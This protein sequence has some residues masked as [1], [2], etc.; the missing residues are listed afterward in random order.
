MS[1]QLSKKICLFTLAIGTVSNLFAAGL[2]GDF[3]MSDRWRR[4][5]SQYSNITNPA[6]INENGRMTGRALFTGVHEISYM[7]EMGFTMPLGL[8]DA[9]G[10]SWIMQ[11][12]GSDDIVDRTQY[13]TLTY[14]RNVWSGLTVGANLNAFTWTLPKLGED[15]DETLMGGGGDIGL[16]WKFEPHEVYG[17]HIAGVSTHNLVTNILKT[18]GKYAAGLRFSLLS[19]FVNQNIDAGLD[20]IV[21]D[22]LADDDDWDLDEDESRPLNWEFT[23]RVGYNILNTVK[24]SALTGFNSDGFDLGAALSVNLSNFLNDQAI[25]VGAQYMAANIGDNPSHKFSFFARAEFGRS[26]GEDRVVKEKPVREKKE[27]I[28][29]EE[30]KEVP[31]ETEAEAVEIPVQEESAEPL[32]EESAHEEPII[33]EQAADEADEEKSEAKVDGEESDGKESAVTE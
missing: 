13:I 7:H 14:A 5:N 1:K 30:V 21:R 27:K 31:S 11:S 24:V 18:S 20:F 12:A 8:Q 10:V 15:G 29:K 19:D 28:V 9:A 6:F 2:A 25:E 16:T 33:E 3:T 4:A 23:Q 17:N 26:R 22:I 32:V